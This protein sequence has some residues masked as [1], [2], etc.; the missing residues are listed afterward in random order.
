MMII[1]TKRL[2]IREM[3]ENDTD[4]LFKV[5][6]DSENMRYYPYPFDKMRVK[7]WIRTNIERYRVFGFGLW[8]VCLKENNELIG[9][10]GLTMQNIN[11][12]IRPEIGYH[13]RADKQRNGYA[14]EAAKAVRDWGFAHTPFKILYSYMRSDNTAS[15]KTAEAVGM[16]LFDR[17]TDDDGDITLV[18]AVHR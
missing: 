12:F 10:C 13:I 4:M 9:D 3:N 6:G 7:N 16:K 5:L 18:Y 15:V 8:G 1:E 14:T 11:G 2:I 17:Y